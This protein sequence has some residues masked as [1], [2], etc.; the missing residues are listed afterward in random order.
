MISTLG[1]DFAGNVHRLREVPQRARNLRRHLWRVWVVLECA[2]EDID[3]A[4]LG[5][6]PSDV[7][8][9]REIAHERRRRRLHLLV[10][11]HLLCRRYDRTDSAELHEPQNELVVHLS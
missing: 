2:D 8:V 9:D 5:D 11:G 6:G 4:L 10:L 1:L 3:T 7:L